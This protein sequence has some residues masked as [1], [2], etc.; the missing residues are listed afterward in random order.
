[1]PLRPEPLLMLRAA[2]A[3]VLLLAATMKLHVVVAGTLAPASLA[4]PAWL[5]TL[6]LLVEAYVAW[7]LIMYRRQAFP[8]LAAQ[9]LF[10]ALF[11][12]AYL[13][14]LGGSATCGCFGTIDL[15]PLAAVLTDASCIVCLWLALPPDFWEKLRIEFRTWRNTTTSWRGISAPGAAGVLGVFISVLI[16]SDWGRGM[17]LLPSLSRIVASAPDVGAGPPDSWVDGRVVVTNTTSV[18]AEVVGQN[19]T[20]GCVFVHERAPRIPSHG[21]VSIPFRMVRPKAA[22]TFQKVMTLYLDHPDQYAV[23]ASI[24]GRVEADGH[25][26]PSSSASLSDL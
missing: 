16:G 15:P 24:V 19:T 9:V 3:A 23:H 2:I 25:A 26:A 21:S 1:M 22:G 8:I 10:V 20:C 17:V 14:W 7:S 11:V 6:L 13:R 12:V 5:T 4:A 18:S